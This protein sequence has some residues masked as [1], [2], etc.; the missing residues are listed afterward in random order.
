MAKV[1]EKPGHVD[2]A[3][4]RERSGVLARPIKRA[5]DLVEHCRL[6]R[7]IE[8]RRWRIGIARVEGMKHKGQADAVVVRCGGI[9]DKIIAVARR[10]TVT[11]FFEKL[12]AIDGDSFR[13]GGQMEADVAGVPPIS[14]DL[15]ME[16]PSST[17][18]STYFSVR[19]VPAVSTGMLI[20]AWISD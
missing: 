19:L 7:S 11:G 20:R 12:N 14:G 5:D 15:Q 8:F 9:C 4:G 17:L 6:S 3:S 10:G 13:C 18:M 16:A 2:Q 1:R